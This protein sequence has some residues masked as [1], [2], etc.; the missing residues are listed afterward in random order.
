M[1]SLFFGCYLGLCFFVCVLIFLMGFYEVYLY[2]NWFEYGYL[3][4]VFKLLLYIN[5]IVVLQ[6]DQLYR[7]FL[8]EMVKW[9]K[10]KKLKKRKED[11]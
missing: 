11:I 9:K 3:K 6:F 8:K 2:S 4:Q 10:V 1:S 7:V 5:E